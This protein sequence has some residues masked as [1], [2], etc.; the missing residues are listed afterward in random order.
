[1]NKKHLLVTI[2][3]GIVIGVVCW[4]LHKNKNN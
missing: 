4:V 1:M 3:G 2:V